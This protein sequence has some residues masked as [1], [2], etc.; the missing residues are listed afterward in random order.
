MALMVPITISQVSSQG[1]KSFYKILEK[2]LPHDFCVWHKQIVQGFCPDFLILSP[3]LGL[4]IIE[5]ISWYPNQI[6]D[7]DSQNFTITFQRENKEVKPKRSDIEISGR[8]TRKRSLQVSEIQEICTSP[9]KQGEE[10]LDRLLIVLK[11]HEILNQNYEDSQNELAFSVGF[12]VVMSNMTETQARQNNIYNILSESQVIYRDELLLLSDTTKINLVSRLKKIF[13]NKFPFTNLTSEQI[14]SVK[15]ILYPEIAIQ[16]IPVPIHSFINSI[17]I[18]NKAYVFRTLDHYQECIARGIGE[19]HRII[20]GVAG[21]GKTLILICHTKLLAN[22]KDIQRILVICFNRTLAAYLK[23]VFDEDIQDQECKRKINVF[24]FYGWARAEINNLPGLSGFSREYYDDKILGYILLEK[25]EKLPNKELYDAVLVDEAQ[26][27]YPTWLKCCVAAL[28]DSENGNLMI[29]SD[30][31]QSLYKRSKYTWKSVGIKAVGRTLSNRIN[32]NRN[33]RNTQEILNAAWY[34]VS[35]IIQQELSNNLEKPDEESFFKIVTPTACLR[36]G[37]R[38]ILQIEKSET[39]EI[40]AVISSIHEVI[41]AGYSENEIAILYRMAWGDKIIFIDTIIKKLH[42]LGINTYWV[43]K[44]REIEQRYSIKSNGIRFINVLSSIGLEFKV[45]F[46]LWVQDWE[47]N[48]PAINESDVLTCKRLY[49]AMTR[50]QDILHI[51]GSG[52]SHLLKELQDSGNF[53][54]RQK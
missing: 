29:V 21:S 5:V 52:S 44:T 31:N 17:Q 25:L 1:E 34:I 42:N 37:I 10:L 2:T 6:I 28:K 27:F 45:V 39:H 30:G 40:E 16:K 11:N 38:P 32:L 36:Q 7:V 19:G 4:L 14:D 15:G 24:T 12:G 26:T 18:K 13:T 46:L 33:Y 23:S 9:L 8:R 53:E 54:V 20:Y 41:M 49:V 50:A 51:F 47:F 22:R 43:S 3:E 48:I 35:H